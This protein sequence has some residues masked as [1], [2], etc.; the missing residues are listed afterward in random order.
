MPAWAD[1]PWW[2]VTLVF[3]PVYM[4]AILV[5]YAFY[6]TP[7]SISALWPASGVALATLALTPYRT[8]P[9]VVVVLVLIEMTV[10]QLLS[11]AEVLSFVS[12]SNVA[13]PI[14]GALLLRWALGPRIDVSRF[15]H[16]V[17]LVLLAAL[18]GPALIAL[19]G[20]YQVTLREPDADFLT[21]W[22]VWWFGS[23]L[24]VTVIAPVVVAWADKWGTELVPKKQLVELVVLLLGIVAVGSWVLGAAPQPFKSILDF[25]FVAFP[26]LIWATLRFDI[27]VVTA[28]SMLVAFFTVWN[29]TVMQRGPFMMIIA[30]TPQ[31]NILAIQA[32]IATSVLSALFLSAALADRRRAA[33]ER[34]V[35]RAQVAE[36]QKLEL[37]ARLAGSVAHDFNNDLTIMMSWADYLE[38]AAG[39]NPDVNRAVSQIS[40]AA[41][42]AASITSQLLSFGRTPPGPKQTVAVV[43]LTPAW[44][45]LLRP[46]FHGSRRLEVTAD[47]DVGYVRADPH[48]LEQV[49]LNLA[50]NARDA[51]PNGGALSVRASRVASIAGDQGRGS[52]VCITVRDEGEGM[53]AEVL[54]RIFE[55]FF[56]TKVDGRGTGLG[57]PSVQRIIE[58]LGG[59]IEVDSNVGRG[60]TF[61][62]Y[63]P[64]TEAPAIALESS[65]EVLTPAS[66][67]IL[68]VDDDDDV[69][70]AVVLALESGGYT[71]LRAADGEEALDVV[72]S[73]A[74]IV[75]LVITD[76]NMPKGG[77]EALIDDLANRHPDL[78]V[79]VVSGYSSSDGGELP[80][81]VM[82]V[83]KPFSSRVLLSCVRE[84]LAG[85]RH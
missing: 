22:Q 8:W 80:D 29:A 12:P 77:G 67:T 46:L 40:R 14:L 33:E 18:I 72:K 28:A 48:Q 9:P 81:D 68:V 61:R 21:V 49:L 5:G 26:L 64:S 4:V 17:G 53:D 30:E 7:D 3:A 52:S 75:D 13:E 51:M 47:P 25:P 44:Q 65:S 74:D 69:R 85:T 27:R 63:L 84:A 16:A 35:L 79:V 24:G 1:A 41:Q 11:D 78:P 34:A 42:R 82:F 19:A 57:L 66:E 2:V 73:H 36:G 6:L 76:L 83:P 50:I 38:S 58:G 60:T 32:F 54:D 10:P 37:V 56:T 62:L 15:R 43:E 23:A 59:R 39:D 71:V 55:P 45:N 70:D 31:A 20:A